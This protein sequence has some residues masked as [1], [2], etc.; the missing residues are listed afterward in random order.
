MSTRPNTLKALCISAA[1]VLLV[2]LTGCRPEGPVFD[3]QSGRWASPLP[4]AAL[5]TSPLPTPTLNDD[6]PPT[7]P[8]S[9]TVPPVPTPLPTPVVTPIPVAVPPFIPEVV[10]KTQ[11]PFWIIY[12]QDN[13]VWRID[14]QSKERQLLVDIYKR[15]GQWL[16]DLPD[17]YKNSDCCMIGPRV[18]V[19]PNGQQL[20]LVVVDKLKGTRE[21]RFT[22]S[23]FVF[24]IPTGNLKLVSEGQFPT[25]SPDGKRIAFVRNLGPAGAAVDGGLWIAD[26]AVDQVYQLI[27][28]DPAKPFLSV[29][30]WTWSPDSQ[31]I[32][33]RFT[34]G[35]S[36]QTEIWIKNIL[37]SSTA[38]LLPNTSDG[39]FYSF[40]SWMPDGEHLL[41]TT[42]DWA[43]PEYP[44][45]L[46]AVTIQTGERKRLDYG[47][48]GGGSEWSPDGQ[49]LIINAVRL[50]ER[51]KYPYDLW[52]LN[53]DGTRLLRVTSAPPEDIG[54]FWSPD[55]TRLVFRRKGV[56]LVALSLQTGS[57]VSLGVN[58]ADAASYNYAVGGTK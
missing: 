43:A 32:A 13:E 47:F 55:G 35:L 23:I 45:T 33:Y 56:G 16:T 49:W 26:L 41:C 34:D 54:A 48:V 8:P 30:Y 24:D 11:Q 9:P 12:W 17:P 51:P 15:L 29:R 44:L 36:D 14:D 31:R 39:T 2:V 1:V 53:A 10:G 3:P 38:Y 40:F 19:S 37:G 50:Y 46:W 4:T 52:L 7:L 20:A 21:D 28:G 22:F 58:L 6:L 42:Q 18:A 25:W 5:P 57:V 27:K